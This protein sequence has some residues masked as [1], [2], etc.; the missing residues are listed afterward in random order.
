MSETGFVMVLIFF[1]FF[2]PPLRARHRPASSSWVTRQFCRTLNDTYY[3]YC[4]VVRTR[5]IIIT[6]HARTRQ[7]G[8]WYGADLII[9][10]R[11]TILHNIQWSWC[12]QHSD[13]IRTA[14]SVP[15][16][17]KNTIRVVFFFF[18]AHLQYNCRYVVW[19]TTCCMIFRTAGEHEGDKRAQR[20]TDKI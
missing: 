12:A 13:V 2:S 11:A 18:Y 4:V 1:L 7:T 10:K 17:E 3:V 15:R 5:P 16:D 20:S 8:S 9:R 19:I 14:R 6:S